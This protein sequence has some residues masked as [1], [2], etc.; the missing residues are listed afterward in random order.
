[1]TERKIITA[2]DPPPIPWRG[3]DFNARREDCDECDPIGYG[4][5]ED[6]AIADL[7][8]ME[9]CAQDEAEARAARKAGAA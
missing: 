2:Y 5:T 8:D 4:F 1:M 9:A 6:E 7:R 3:Y